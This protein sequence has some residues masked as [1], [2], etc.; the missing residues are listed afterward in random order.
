MLPVIRIF[1]PRI[2]SP[3]ESIAKLG[4]CARTHF[5]S[6]AVNCGIYSP[7]DL[8]PPG[9]PQFAPI[10]LR[11]RGYDFTLVEHY[12]YYLTRLA[13]NVGVPN[14]KRWATPAV[15]TRVTSFKPQSSLLQNEY[16]L[17]LFER[18]VLLTGASVSILSTLLDVMNSTLPEGV[19]VTAKV[20]E[21]ADEEMRRVPDYELVALKGQLA[22]MASER[23]KKKKG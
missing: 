3:W 4:G 17:N 9:P 8:P 23:E 21:P 14:T 15:S 22:E 12:M 10:N 13:H 7:E 5:S 18:N 2:S 11:I 20:M 6:S 19:S 1:V 16:E